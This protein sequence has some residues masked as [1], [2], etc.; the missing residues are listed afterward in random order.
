MDLTANVKLLCDAFLTLLYPQACVIC[1]HSVERR[2]FGVACEEC[3][4][5][6]LLFTGNETICW[7]CG[8]PL[9]GSLDNSGRE[10]VRCHRCDKHAFTAARACG[11]Y[12]TALRETVLNLKRQPYLPEMI[13]HLLVNTMSREPLNKSTLIVPVPLH[14]RR[15]QMR[16]FNQA[17]VIARAVSTSVRL[18][19]NEV[20]LIR[21]SHTEKYRA[22]LDA[23]GRTDTVARAFAVVHPRLIAGEKIL[24]VDDVFTT[25]A[26]SSECSNALLTA[27]AETVNV[28]T[29]ARTMR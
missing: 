18:P 5:S 17:S 8:A 7:K 29:I 11:L 10:E 23:K 22:G 19:I 20:S 14:A 28:L 15:L 4:Q 2:A 9:A 21:T 27:G 6:T 26:T 24:L 3:W 25:G 12:E 16:G 1:Q 13:S